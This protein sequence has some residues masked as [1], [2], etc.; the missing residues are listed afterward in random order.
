MNRLHILLTVMVVMAGALF[1][2]Q[3]AVAKVFTGTAGNDTLVG[4]NMDDRLDGRGGDDTIR[5]AGG[6]DEI[7]PGEGDDKVF[8]GAGDDNV[9]ARDTNG[10]DFIDCGDGFDVVETIHRDDKTKRNC[11][12]A[13]G[14]QRTTGTTTGATDTTGTTGTTTRTTGTTTGTSTTGTTGTTGTT[15]GTRRTP[16]TTTGTTTGTT[17]TT[18][19]Q[20]VVP[21]QASGLPGPGPSEGCNYPRQIA[22]FAGQVQ[23]STEPFEVPSEVMRVRYFIEPIEELGNVLVVDVF[24]EG[25]SFPSDFFITPPVRTPTGRSEILQLDQRGT[26]FLEIEPHDVTYQIAVDACE[27]DIGPITGTTTGT[28][29]AGDSTSTR[30]NVIRDTIPQSRELPNTGGGLSMLVPAVAVL[31]LLI[32]GSAIGLLF[33]RQR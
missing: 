20:G 14:P 26:Y 18:G 11:E 4:T 2:S 29:T 8:A 33:M 17:D 12:R 28:T 16:G 24:K 27:G 25:E 21:G 13:P 15:T 32:S 9:F 22:T 19:E 30:D 7:I 31:A 5:G 1:A 10:V 6:D 23:R 3:E